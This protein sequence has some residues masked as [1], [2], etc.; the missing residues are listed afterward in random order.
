MTLNTLLQTAW[1]ILLQRYSGETD[2]VFGATR[3][4]RRSAFSG[5]RRDDRAV[6]QHAADSRERWN[7]TVASTSCCRK[8]GRFRSG[9]A[10]HE[11][12]PLVKVQGWSEVPRGRP[13]FDTILVYDDR[14]LDATLRTLDPDGGPPHVRLSRPDE[15]PA[16][17]HRLRRGRDAGAARERPPAAS[18]THRRRDARPPRDAPEPHARARGDTRSTSCRCCRTKEREGPRAGSGRAD[19]RPRS[20]PSRAL[21]GAGERWR[22]SGWRR[23]CDGESL[24]YRELD[25]RAN[26]AGRRAARARGRARRA[27]RAADGAVARAGRRD[28]GDP[29]GGRRVPA[30]RPGLPA[31]AGR[32]MLE[33]SGV[34]VVVTESGFAGRLR[35]E[36]GDARPGSTGTGRGAERRP[37]PAWRAGQPGVRDLHLGLD[38]QAEGRAHHARQRRAP[39]RRDRRAGSASATDDVWTLFHSYAF[40]FSVWEL[41]GALLYGGRLVVVPYW[42]S[43]SPEAFR[44]LLVRRA[45]D[46]AQPDAVRVPP[47]DRRP[48]RRPARP[49]AARCGTSIFGGEALELQSLRPWFERHGDDAAA[50]RQHV[51]HHRD[52]G[53]RH[54]PADRAGRSARRRRAA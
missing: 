40:D 3:A 8:S 11:H 12:T 6:H 26:A 54:L 22:R 42:V 17:P 20:M 39:V 5:R 7:P 37:T 19:V 9:C 23:S 30:A 36:S 24:T 10:Q 21:R 28:P 32:F 48:T 46:G 43:R 52:D 49:R 50:A 16:H 51:R 18:T 1:A 33:D 45:R 31:G 14:T 44:E 41:W 53:A 13:L 15:L 2:V 27:G 34:G 29:Q 35:G 4:C 25:R 47:A 38:G